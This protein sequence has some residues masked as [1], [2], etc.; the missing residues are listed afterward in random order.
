MY[1]SNDRDLKIAYDLLYLIENGLRTGMKCDIEKTKAHVINLKRDIRKYQKDH[2]YEEFPKLV[3]DDGID[4]YTELIRLPDGDY[5]IEELNE[6][7]EEEIW[8]HARPSIYDCTGQA[9]TQRYK[10]CKRRGMN[11]CYHEI[12]FDV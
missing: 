5:S 6:Y 1:I 9:F 10:V 2:P 11:L 8:I 4:G 3:H 12:G 7:V